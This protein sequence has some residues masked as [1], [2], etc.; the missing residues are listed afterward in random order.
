MNKFNIKKYTAYFHDGYLLDIKHTKENMEIFMESAQIDPDDMKDNIQLSKHG[1][2]KG[3]LHVEKIKE[4][5]VNE[6][7]L[8]GEWEKPYDIGDIYEFNILDNVIR[9]VICWIDYSSKSSPNT[10]MW[11]NYQINA[12]KIYWENI[13]DL[14]NPYWPD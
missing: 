2:I 5:R 3:K 14:F 6:E 4:I 9:F 10:N 8:I 13:P 7:L 11:Y 12:K 1:T